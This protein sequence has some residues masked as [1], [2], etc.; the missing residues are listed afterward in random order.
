[1]EPQST[2]SQMVTMMPWMTTVFTLTPFLLV[3]A[4]DFGKNPGKIYPLVMIVLCVL[5]IVLDTL[6]G[7]AVAMTIPLDQLSFVPPSCVSVSAHTMMATPINM[8]R[9]LL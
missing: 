9:G 4:K 3:L 6:G 8:T 7:M 2:A 5:T 1:M